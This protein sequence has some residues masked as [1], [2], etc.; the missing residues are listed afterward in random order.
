[1]GTAW[2]NC[3]ESSDM[4]RAPILVWLHKWPMKHAYDSFP[5]R[6]QCKTSLHHEIF[7]FVLQ[8]SNYL[9][10]VYI[11]EWLWW[12]YWKLDIFISYEKMRPAACSTAFDFINCTINLSHSSLDKAAIKLQLVTFSAILPMNI[13]LFWYVVFYS[14]SLGCD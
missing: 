11:C 7:R 12:F 5:N 10:E 4:V 6:L 8:E 2:I 9:K 1:M 14:C 3:H 13:C